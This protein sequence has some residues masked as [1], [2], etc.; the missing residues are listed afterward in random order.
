MGLKGR[1]HD[2]IVCKQFAQFFSSP[3]WLAALA[4][5]FYENRAL[6]TDPIVDLMLVSGRQIH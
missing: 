5:S 2:K 6:L 1:G 4:S 3:N